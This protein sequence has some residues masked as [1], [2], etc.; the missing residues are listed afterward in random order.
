MAIGYLQAL[1]KKAF[2]AL[3]QRRRTGAIGVRHAYSGRKPLIVQ[4]HENQMRTL[5][6]QSD[7]DAGKLA[8]ATLN[9][10]V[11]LSLGA[12]TSRLDGRTLFHRCTHLYRRHRRKQ[13]VDPGTG[14]HA[15]RN[16]EPGDRFKAE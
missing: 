15:S 5:L 11:L 16:P 13:P 12:S 3:Q 14:A 2:A 1:V 9:R 6:A 8:G 7:C 4:A 10:I